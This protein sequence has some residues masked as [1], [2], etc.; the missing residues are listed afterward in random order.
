MPPGVK[1]Y[2]K[3]NKNDGRDAEGACEAMGRIARPGETQPTYATLK[4]RDVQ[5]AAVPSRA[6]PDEG[7]VNYS[8]M[9]AMLDRVGGVGLGAKCRPRGK[10]EDGLAWARPPRL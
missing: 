4:L 6:E 3:R 10:T 5:I 2:V 9:F 8:A 1:P 7:E